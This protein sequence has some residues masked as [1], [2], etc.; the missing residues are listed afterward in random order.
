MQDIWKVYTNCSL[1]WYCCEEYVAII[2][3]C[4]TGSVITESVDS[5]CRDS[6]DTQ[7]MI[8]HRKNTKPETAK[9]FFFVSSSFLLQMG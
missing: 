1:L 6:M 3:V 9:M 4:V 2:L 5:I 7:Y 8:K